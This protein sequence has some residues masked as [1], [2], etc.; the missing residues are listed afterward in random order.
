MVA[1]LESYN[2]SYPDD[3]VALN[4]LAE[5]DQANM[6]VFKK[7]IFSHQ[8]VCDLLNYVSKNDLL[9]FNNTRVM[10][11]RLTGTRVRSDEGNIKSKVS[12]TLNKIIDQNVWTTFCKPLK[13]LREDDKI[14]FSKDLSAA[15]ISLQSGQCVMNFETGG[16]EFISCLKE[17]GD[18][19]LPPYIIKKRSPKIVAALIDKPKSG[20]KANLQNI[21]CSFSL[22]NDNIKV[23]ISLTL[24]YV[25]DREVIMVEY[26]QPNHWVG[27]SSASR[28]GPVL[29][30]QAIIN[31]KTGPIRSI[32]RSKVRITVVSTTNSVNA[33]TCSN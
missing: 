8:K 6:L 7:N 28:S 19:P 14:I 11:C 1:D 10:P 12:V 20:T 16:K 25:G 21:A 27:L 22:S 5:K 3:L 32:E 2:F 26:E 30:A 17:I 33:G 9:V 18:M 24:P 15:V 29:N 23:R 13:K 4:P 31:N